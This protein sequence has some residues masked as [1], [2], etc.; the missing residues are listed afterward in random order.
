MGARHSVAGPCTH[1]DVS[2]AESRTAH[3]KVL[4]ADLAGRPELV[5][6]GGDFNAT[7][8]EPSMAAFVSP[9]LNPK[10]QGD[11]P[12]TIPAGE[13]RR[14]IDFILIKPAEGVPVPMVTRYEV[15]EEKVASDHRPVVMEIVQP[16]KT[17]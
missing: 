13:P 7:P 16:P 10:K 2:V 5:L 14:E 9:W 12:G 8:D 3:A 1:L 15:I 11:N 6:L 17:S 4:A